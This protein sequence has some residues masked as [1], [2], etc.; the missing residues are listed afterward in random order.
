MTGVKIRFGSIDDLEILLEHR[1][2]MWNEIFPHKIAEVEK[3]RGPTQ[4]WLRAKLGSGEMIALIA[5][6][7][8]TIYGSGCILIKEDQVR[9]GS[10]S[11]ICP[12]LLSVFTA[13]EHRKR[14]IASLITEQAIK[15]AKENGYDR[16]ELHASPMGKKIYESMGFKATNEM[17]M[18][19]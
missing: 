8:S 14:G 11:A 18:W 6:Q 5:Y 3:S 10:N 17:R 2:K 1:L 12:Y 4:Q 7:G 13:P 16:M 9:P 19:F 15:W